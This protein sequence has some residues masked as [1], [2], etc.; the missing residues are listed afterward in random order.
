MSKKSEVDITRLD[1]ISNGCKHK[2]FDW[3]IN[4]AADAAVDQAEKEEGNAF[5]IN[6]DGIQ[7]LIDFT[8]H[9][10]LSIIAAEGKC[11]V[12]TFI[13]VNGIIINETCWFAVG[14][15]KCDCRFAGRAIQR[16]AAR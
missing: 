5:K 9:K 12:N 4:G 10:N 2:T 6:V 11:V 16:D 15:G 8:E 13:M 14:R 3:I 1:T 7:N